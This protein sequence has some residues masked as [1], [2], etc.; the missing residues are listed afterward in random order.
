MDRLSGNEKFVYIFLFLLLLLLFTSVILYLYSITDD[1]MRSLLRASSH[2]YVQ[3]KAFF[4]IFVSKFTESLFP[5]FSFFFYI[6][7]TC[8]ENPR[9]SSRPKRVLSAECILVLFSYLWGRKE[10][11][12]RDRGVQS[13]PTAAH[14]ARTT[15]SSL[16]KNL[17][18]ENLERK[19]QIT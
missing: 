1:H 3:T 15:T 7:G 11:P 10:S 17:Q 6:N 13:G 8:I 18:Y 14:A 2:F 9:L 4:S 19:A 16:D 12:K 5:L